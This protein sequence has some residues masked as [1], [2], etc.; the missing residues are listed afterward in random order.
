M[1]AFQ[2]ACSASFQQSVLVD[3]HLVSGLYTQGGLFWG[4]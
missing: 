2:S 1:T 4:T 3:G